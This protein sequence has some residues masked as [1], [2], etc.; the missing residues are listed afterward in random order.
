MRKINQIE[1][2]NETTRLRQVSFYWVF[3]P[4]GSITDY[5]RVNYQSLLEKNYKPDTSGEAY[6]GGY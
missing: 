3:N 6:L 5:S 2:K 4:D 1:Q